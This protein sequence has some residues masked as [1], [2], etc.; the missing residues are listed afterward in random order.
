M[1]REVI[2]VG[3]GPGG[4]TTAMA[5]AKR[6]RDVLLIDRQQFPRDKTC[7]DAV[8][9]S[10]VEYLYDLGLQQTFEQANFYRIDDLLISSGQKETLEAPLNVG[11][12]YGAHSYIAP[13]MQFD[14][15]LQQQAIRNGAEFC[16]GVVKK[17]IVEDGKVVG[18]ECRH[19]GK[20]ETIRSKIIVGADGVT[21][22]IT[23][24]L[25]PE[26][27]KH[28]DSH[29]AIALRAYIEDLEILPHQAEFY[30]YKE[31]LPGYA[32]I[33][34]LGEDQAN[35]GLGMR[36]DTYRQQ[37]DKLEE[38]LQRFLD[39]PIIKSRLKRGGV[40]RDVATWQLNFG[41][42]KALQH[43]YDGALLVGDAAGLINPLTGGG[44]D[45]AIISG[46]L[47]AQTIDEALT[48]GDLS[49]AR[50]KIYESLVHD[51]LWAEMRRAYKFQQL[52]KYT[53]FLVRLIIKR[54]S[55][56]SSFAKMFL[57][58]L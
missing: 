30:L 44:I 6:G 51:A 58:K 45:N 24:A 55:S 34:P 57:S 35:I 40:V 3:A 15:L 20:T 32:W 18:V 27:N 38:M 26:N 49:S 47:A 31:I 5:L 16:V 8:P 14:A 28:L 9:A 41:S 42:Q 29:R 46:M 33:F 10:A 21:S 52:M 2:V 22:S 37:K 1:E 43:V 12:K 54:M 53:P 7:G 50:L 23:R 39:M 36:L 11:E 48:N 17:P 13:R 4:A 25:R 56:N 19:N